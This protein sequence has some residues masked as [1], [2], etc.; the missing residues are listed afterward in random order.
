[1]LSFS[2]KF[3]GSELKTKSERKKEEGVWKSALINYLFEWF[4]KYIKLKKGSRALMVKFSFIKFFYFLP[5]VVYYGV[6]LVSNQASLYVEPV[7]DF[8]QINK[9]NENSWSEILWT[10]K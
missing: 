7:Q 5:G 8:V 3:W 10:Q 1:M 9:E 6:P 4:M 2:I